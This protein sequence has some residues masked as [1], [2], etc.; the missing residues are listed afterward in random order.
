MK[1]W[2]RIAT[3]V[4][5]L[6]TLSVGAQAQY[7]GGYVSGGASLGGGGGVGVY[8][9]GGVYTGGVSCPYQQRTAQNAVSQDDDV[10]EKQA[11]LDALKKSKSD[12]KS[13]VDRLKTDLKRSRQ[14][15]TDV[16]A[17]EYAD[18]IF[19]HIESLTRSCSAYKGYVDPSGPGGGGDP[20]DF[21][22]GGKAGDKS[23]QDEK[24]V[25]ITAFKAEEWSQ[26]C[27]PRLPSSVSGSV[28]AV[29]TFRNA[30]KA[31]STVQ[32][33]RKGLVDY[34]T[35]YKKQQALQNQMDDLD[36]QIKQAQYDLEDA[37]KVAKDKI[38]SDLEAGICENCAM[39]GNGY[40]YQQ[41][42]PNWIGA[43]ASVAGGLLAYNLVNKNNE[44]LIQANSNLGYQTPYT[45]PAGTVAAPFILSAVSNLAGGGGGL[46]G[47]MASGV[48][49]GS[50][51]CGQMA[52]GQGA[53]GQ[54][55][56][57]NPYM[58][59]MNTMGGGMYMNPLAAM[60]GMNG[61]NGMYPNVMMGMNGMYPNGMMGMNGM[62]PNGMMGMNGMYP[63]M[64]GMYP[65]MGMNGM[66]PGMGMNGMYPNGMMGMN[67]MYPGMSGMYPGM[68]M[69]G[70]YPGMSGMYPGMYGM[71]GMYPGMN[72]MYPGMNGGMDTMGMQ[73]QQQ[74]MQMQMQQLQ[75]QQQQQQA[76]YQQYQQ[77]L[78]ASMSVQQEIQSLY[79]KLQMINMGYGTSTGYLGGT[80]TGIGGTSGGTGGS[81]TG[82]GVMSGSGL[83][84]NGYY[85]GNGY[86][87]SLPIGP[88]QIS[89]TTTTSGAVA[90]PR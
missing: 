57:G 31:R 45:M 66:Y 85:Y 22:A 23:I 59:G 5:L 42:Q 70:M 76:Y 47:G 73:Y 32:D 82:S 18:F 63:G 14:S 77:K 88:T 21:K 13:Q 46:Y 26:Y 90:A 81:I 16:I 20:A 36:S 69:N 86:S 79:Y 15:I 55:I 49:Q 56:N 89:P 24:N 29:Q 83:Y 68:G 9:N 35:N 33:C 39:T 41:P 8:P 75:M 80:S 48:G 71:N 61:M 52:G 11:N 37:Q 60:M 34:R 43:A 19:E 27:D 65:G 50:I 3:P 58:N 64:N 74:M 87:S 7:I 38:K 17:P 51:G 67:G 10:K 1:L 84:N 30:E 53:Y 44:A 12:L 40:T 6:M 2:M 28:C 72:G 25:P 4:T 78:S 54:Y 62:Y